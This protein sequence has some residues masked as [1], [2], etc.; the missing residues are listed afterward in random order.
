LFQ[1]VEFNPYAVG[2]FVQLLGES[3]EVPA[4]IVV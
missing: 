1:A 2:I 4:E 3:L